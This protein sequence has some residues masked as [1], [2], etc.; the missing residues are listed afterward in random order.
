V[1]RPAY[2]PRIIANACKT[3]LCSWTLQTV[4][5]ADFL[6]E[7]PPSPTTPP[8]AA[9]TA[10][11]PPPLSTV[12]SPGDDGKGLPRQRSRSFAFFNRRPASRTAS[13]VA[14]APPMVTALS[15]ESSAGANA[16]MPRGDTGVLLTV[17]PAVRPGRHSAGP[18][19][20]I[21]VAT[22]VAAGGA[23][24]P[25]LASSR[26]SVVEGG[27]DANHTPPLPPT[28][29][30]GGG[31]T[32]SRS[33]LWSFARR[34]HSNEHPAPDAASP[35][36]ASEPAIHRSATLSSRRA[37][38][39][40][41]NLSTRWATLHSPRATA[42]AAASAS[43]SPD[44]AQPPAVSLEETP[45]SPTGA[46]E[47]AAAAPA[48]APRR[49]GASRYALLFAHDGPVPTAYGQRWTTARRSAPSP[50]L[51]PDKAAAAAVP[52]AWTLHR[53]TSTELTSTDMSSTEPSTEALP[54][55]PLAALA[56]PPLPALRRDLAVVIEHGAERVEL[57]FPANATG[58]DVLRAACDHFEY[59]DDQSFALY[60]VDR[61]RV[62]EDDDAVL[63]L[64]ASH[65]ARLMVRLVAAGHGLALGLNPLPARPSPPAAAA[66]SVGRL[67][68]SSSLLVR[69]RGTN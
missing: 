65:E 42:P 54:M 5:L 6:N 66:P 28:G 19:P 44:A 7:G 9:I 63:D 52:S 17:P 39:E 26:D 58:R 32:R 3:P 40:R 53:S 30:N 59:W 50:S 64:L 48:D 45:L 1:G 38:A 69:R 14:P 24:S 34:V 47:D 8:A 25:L 4:A 62:I 29:P 18:S 2:A 67:A 57:H 10:M 55:A 49:R 61:Q 31:G 56:S 68:S 41:L 23:T 37:F 11:S 21:P 46:T 51:S 20:R 22:L 13:S 27:S 43:A 60:A 36:P 33:A 16:A 12:S 35:P 15:S